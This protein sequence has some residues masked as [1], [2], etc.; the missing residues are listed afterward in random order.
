MLAPN[1]SA[2]EVEIDAPIT[3]SRRAIEYGFFTYFVVASDKQSP[4]AIPKCAALCCKTIN[5]MVDKVTIH[6][7]EYPNVAPAARLD[8][9]FPGSINPTVTRS[10]G[11]IYFKILKEPGRGEGQALLIDRPNNNFRRRIEPVNI[12]KPR[13][14]KF[15]K[16]YDFTQPIQLKGAIQFR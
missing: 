14:V 1:I 13:G 10:P 5:M 4:V 3:E 9:Q 16:A 6:N 7:K 11:P 12:D 2:K 8:A 15:T